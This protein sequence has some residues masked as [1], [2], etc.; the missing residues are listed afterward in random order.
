MRAVVGRVNLFD[1]CFDL[2][3]PG[4]SSHLADAQMEDLCICLWASTA[5]EP[6]ESAPESRI[7]QIL[8]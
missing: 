7:G 3:Y 1:P 5:A 2:K 6:P 8:I 4:G